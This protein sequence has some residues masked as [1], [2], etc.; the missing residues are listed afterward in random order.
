MSKS[1]SL[2]EQGYL[3][4]IKSSNLKG[5]SENLISEAKSLISEMI[6]KQL[7][8]QN[9]KSDLPQFI[10]PNDNI[11]SL[12]FEQNTKDKVV[13]SIQKNTNTDQILEK[14]EQDDSTQ[15]VEQGH[16]QVEQPVFEQSVKDTVPKF[17]QET[18]TN[19]EILEKNWED[20]SQE[21]I[22]A[23]TTAKEDFIPNLLPEK[24]IHFSTL[25][26]LFILQQR[27]G[28]KLRIALHE[29]F[30]DPETPS[31]ELPNILQ[32]PVQH[33][34]N[35][36]WLKTVNMVGINVRTIYNFWNV[37]KYALTLSGT[38]NSIHFLPIWEP[39]VVGSLYG[40]ASWHLNTAFFSQELADVC[41]HLDTVERQFKAVVNIL[42]LM[43][44]TVGMDVIPHTDRYAEVVLANPQ[45][46]EWLQ[47]KGLT[48]LN[49]QANLHEMVQDRI[50][51][52]LAQYG[53]ANEAT[54]PT[55]RI[56]FFS[57]EFG[58]AKRLT[59]LFGEKEP[60][61][62]RTE[63]RDEVMRH[64]ILEGYEP[65]PATMAP[66]YRGLEVDPDN[67]E[68]DEKGFQW[69][70]YKITKPEKMSRVFGPLT[71][72]K[73]YDRLADN[74]AWAIDFDTP[75]IDT[76][77]YV[78][79]RYYAVQQA[80]N[81][82]F[83]RGDM[84]HVQMRIEGV[85]TQPDAYYDILGAVKTYINEQGV[86]YFGYFAETFLVPPNTMGYGDEVAH[87]VASNAD[88]TLGDLQSSIVGSDE[89][90]GLFRKYLD[91]L[92]HKP[93]APN[94]TIMTADKD[95]PRF[96]KFYVGGNEIR[97]FIGLF[98]TDMPSYMGLG[99]ETR[100]VHLSPAPN[101]HYTKLYVF[102]IE[103]GPKKTEGNYQWGKNGILF[104]RLTRLRLYTDSI[105]SA[106]Q[107][108][109]VQWL[110]YPS[111]FAIQRII[112]WTQKDTPS[113]VF[114][115]NL[116]IDA[117][118][119]TFDEILFLVLPEVTLTFEFSTHTTFLS[120][121]FSP[122]QAGEGRVYRVSP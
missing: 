41:P 78:C 5:D 93:V 80:Y 52:F 79:E 22:E 8:E 30:T 6:D 120:D 106:I 89:F 4:Q 29:R 47:R 103:K 26:T 115:A 121:T 11:E 113:Y 107:S 69:Q 24:S 54:Y 83:M 116:D 34:P 99:F 58:E 9:I 3:A 21:Y 81:L 28:L 18:T 60:L 42:H 55:D 92:Y 57:N 25:D 12:V 14:N 122:L 108:Q 44:K 100:D 87:L 94:F 49:H 39:G 16:N 102:Q 73:L 101:E 95:D 61:D 31:T 70:E 13:E 36:N 111:P 114:V 62:T 64:L 23:Y 20:N 46:F 10:Q 98:L 71:R 104:H 33:Q 45:H 38:Q 84:S 68:I 53:A 51:G 117:A 67:F 109:A 85:P 40:M 74:Q 43:G 110:I 118:S 50:M 86:P 27:F 19:Y 56:A 119:L 77:Q 88:S 91:I 76:W 72:Y 35:G 75:K 48:I 59:V 17:I 105:W 66:P 97:L 1:Y 32:S 63:R 96:D 7:I 112:A 37:I 82:D 2:P 90:I 65:V 15:L